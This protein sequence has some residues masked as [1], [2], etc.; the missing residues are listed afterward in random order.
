MIR[1]LNKVVG[2]VKNLVNRR[3]NVVRNMKDVRNL[4]YLIPN[5]TVTDL[6]NVIRSVDVRNI[7][8]LFI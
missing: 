5:G 2:K 4:S 7:S 6:K 8:F 1:Y 3:S